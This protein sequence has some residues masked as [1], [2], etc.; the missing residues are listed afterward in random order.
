M[1]AR[2]KVLK[3]YP[4]DKRRGYKPKPCQLSPED[5]EKLRHDPV[6]LEREVL[7]RLRKN[8]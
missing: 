5:L 7:E 4:E 6:A 3:K 1:S 8:R 2:E